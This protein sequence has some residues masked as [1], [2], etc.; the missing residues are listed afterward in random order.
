MHPPASD[1]F[2]SIYH[3]SYPRYI[4]SG[5]TL[6]FLS[7]GDRNYQF[8]YSILISTPNAAIT[9]ENCLS[10]KRPSVP[11]IQNLEIGTTCYKSSEPS[12]T[13][14]LLLHILSCLGKPNIAHPLTLPTRSI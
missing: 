12:S 7:R 6:F 10:I 14:V 11:R 9:D 5:F 1:I 8:L 3:I 2:L 13:C 4:A